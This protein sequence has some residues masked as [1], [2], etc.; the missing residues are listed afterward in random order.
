MKKIIQGKMKLDIE[1][2]ISFWKKM[3]MKFLI[4]LLDFNPQ[5][6]LCMCSFWL[7]LYYFTSSKVKLVKIDES[8]NRDFF[9][10]VSVKIYISNVGNTL[11]ILQNSRQGSK[12]GK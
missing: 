5:T 1:K 3:R 9:I 2:I 8:L 12:K 4:Q 6:W 11:R 10:N 7:K